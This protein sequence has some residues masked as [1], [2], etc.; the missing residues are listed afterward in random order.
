MD[1]G[2]AGRKRRWHAAWREHSQLRAPLDGGGGGC[3]GPLGQIRLDELHDLLLGFG[4]RGRL[5]FHLRRGE[6]QLV[7]PGCPVQRT[8]RSRLALEGLGDPILLILGHQ[9]IDEPLGLGLKKTD[10]IAGQQ[11]IQSIPGGEQPGSLTMAPQAGIKPSCT[12]GQPI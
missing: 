12:S 7:I 11:Q 1:A 9:A 4:E 5:L 3:L 2:G 10:R 8:V 6:L